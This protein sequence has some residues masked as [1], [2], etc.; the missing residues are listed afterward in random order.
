V[1]D[2][3]ERIRRLIEAQG[4]LSIAQFMSQA[5]HDSQSGYY[6]TRDPFGRGGDFITAPEIS[7]MFGELLGL[8]TVQMWRDQ[9]APNPARLIELGPGR[10]TLMADML[11][12][13]GKAAPDFLAAIDVVMVENSPAL[14][15]VQRETLKASGAPVEWRVSFDESLADRPLYVLANEFFDA[16]PI[17]QYV[18]SEDGWRERMVTLGQA[19][20]L[21]F[22]LAPITAKNLA[23]PESRGEAAPGAVYEI[24][25]AAIAY[26]EEIAGAIARRGGAAL[27]ID[28]GYGTGAGFGDTL[29]A[30]KAHKCA[31][32]LESPGEAD[33]TA[34]VDFAALARA[35]ERS[36]ARSFGPIGQ[37]A[38]LERL[39]LRARAAQLARANPET[40]AAQEAAADRLMGA[41]EMGQ[42]FKVLAILPEDAGPPPGFERS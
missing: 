20:A 41:R 10:G 29:Q 21:T 24:A 8:W 17:R 40:A 34:H 5:L 2:L 25:P 26:A 27:L 13:A 23:V 30:V 42:L 6:A 4:P 37:G 39:G 3:G 15:A 36:K 14:Q 9:G 12:A 11:R 31:P 16:L 19:G 32:V 22:A 35:A 7:Q 18:M 38:F 1:N 28:Y 33:L